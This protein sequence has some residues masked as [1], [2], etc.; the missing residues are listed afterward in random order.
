[1]LW[2]QNNHL[3]SQ[4]LM[5]AFQEDTTQEKKQCIRFLE[6]ASSGLPYTEMLRTITEPVMYAKELGNHPEEMKFL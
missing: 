1:V 3:S 2:G 6:L 5:K 4:N